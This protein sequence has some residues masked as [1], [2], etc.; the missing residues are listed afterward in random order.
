MRE[1]V[2]RLMP[3]GQILHPQAG[4]SDPHM[5]LPDGNCAHLCIAPWASNI[6]K[7]SP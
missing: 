6:Y 2:S 7:S 1:Y 5:T 3:I 4:T